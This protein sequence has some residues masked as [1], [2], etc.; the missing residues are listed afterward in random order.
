VQLINSLDGIAATLTTGVGDEKTA[1]SIFGIAFC[2][3]IADVYDAICVSR[4]QNRLR[5]YSTR[6][7]DSVPLINLVACDRIEYRRRVAG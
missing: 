3:T 6:R 5:S 2:G 1:F 7:L 4:G